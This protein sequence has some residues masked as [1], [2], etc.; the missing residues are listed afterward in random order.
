[1]DYKEYLTESL[2]TEKY[3]IKSVDD[4]AAHDD[5]LEAVLD[6]NWKYI[7]D[8]VDK[9]DIPLLIS[10][11]WNSG[12]DTSKMICTNGIITGSFFSFTHTLKTIKIPSYITKIGYVAFYECDHL[13]SVDI[14]ESVISIGNYAFCDCFSLTSIT[15]PEGLIAIGDSAFYGCSSLKSIVIPKGVTYLGHDVFSQ[16]DSLEINYSGTRLEWLK[17]KGS[18]DIKQKVICSDGEL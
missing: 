14:P 10:F 9:D 3:Q 18:N 5:I 8:T 15:I 13:T 6:D 11:L 2:S 16:C 17:I 4:L 12:I 1:M 7:E